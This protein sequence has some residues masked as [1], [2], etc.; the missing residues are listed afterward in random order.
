M[1]KGTPYSPVLA[2]MVVAKL[3]SWQVPRLVI[4]GVAKGSCQGG[5]PSFLGS[6]A[7]RG[8]EV[9]LSGGLSQTASVLEYLTLQLSNALTQV[10]A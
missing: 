8:Y 4:S 3:D 10:G 5:Q 9:L 1:V 6:W 2:S 7:T